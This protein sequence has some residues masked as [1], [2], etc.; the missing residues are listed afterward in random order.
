M[1]ATPGRHLLMRRLFRAVRRQDWFQVLLELAIVVA[2]ILIALQVDNWNEQRK[3]REQAQQWRQQLV[4]DLR[5]NQRDLQGRM[6]YNAQ[7]LAFGEAALALLEAPEAPTGEAAWD[8]VLGAFQAGQI[9]PYRISGPTFREVQSA[10]GLGLVGN[11]RAQVALA[12]FYDVSAHDYELVSGGLPA[13]RQLVRERLDWS[14]QRHIWDSDCQASIERDGQGE[15]DTAFALVR[16]PAPADASRVAAAV[17]ALRNDPEL[18]RA[19]RGRLSQLKVSQS[20][21]QRQIERA[22]AVIGLLAP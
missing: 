7:A 3:A 12:Y 14:L 1:Q 16:C 20:S 9:W 4:A 17:D 2:G 19:L 22:E 13:Y 18:Q 21:N 8:A 15:N 6:D 10:G 11:P 5:Q